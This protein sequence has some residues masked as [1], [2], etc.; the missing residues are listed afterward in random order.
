MNHGKNWTEDIP[1]NELDVIISRHTLIGINE[2][3]NKISPKYHYAETYIIP[4]IKEIPH[5]GNILE[6]SGEYY[7]NLTPSCDIA[8]KAKLGKLSSFSLLKIESVYNL[9]IVKSKTTEEKKQ[10]YIRDTLKRNQAE[11]YHYLPPFN[12]MLES[13]IDFQSITNVKEDEISNYN[14]KASIT[15]Q[16]LKD[17]QNRYSSYLGRQGQ[18]NYL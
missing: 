11:R 15:I 7:I 1:K 10:L 9:D 18:P 17:I 2:E 3:L 4:S 5:T 12:F 13:V 14:S 16:F 6:L 8:E